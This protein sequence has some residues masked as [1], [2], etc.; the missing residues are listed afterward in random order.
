MIQQFTETLPRVFTMIRLGQNRKFIP[1]QMNSNIKT[2]EN[3]RQTLNSIVQ[4]DIPK[5]QHQAEIA[6]PLDVKK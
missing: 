1:K 3:L 2:A 5:A 6:D 4:E